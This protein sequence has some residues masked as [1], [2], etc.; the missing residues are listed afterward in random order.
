MQQTTARKRSR[1]WFRNTLPFWLILPT[2]A[3]LLTIQVY[4]ALYTVWLSLQ[5]REPQGWRFVG[6]DNFRRLFGMGVFGESIGHT[7]VFLVGYVSL[8]LVIGFFIALLLNR[9]LRFSG[10]YVTLLFIPWIIADIIVGIVFRLLVMPDY[11][12][13]SGI[14]QNPALFPPNG[15]SV[16]TAVPPASWVGNFPFPPAPAMVYLIMA[17]SWRALPFITLLLLAAMQTVPVEVVESSRIDGAN[18]W[19]I[20]RRIM[21]PLMLPTLVVAI[22]SLTLSG[23]NGVGMVFSLTGGGPGSSTE[24]LSYM[25]YSLGWRQLEFGRAAALALLIAAVNWILIFATL[26][27]T[28]VEERNN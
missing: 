27:V 26:R 28:R 20:V 5:T 11:G 6:M 1:R 3:V 13:L 12:L 25:L 17:A 19:Q 9:K 24:V 4:P 18:G 15:L 22:F 14:L 8:T 21:I 23:M 10:L 7:V 16:L 2:V